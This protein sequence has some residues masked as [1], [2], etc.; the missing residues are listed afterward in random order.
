MAGKEI[1]VRGVHPT[2]LAV[3]DAQAES[4]N[5][6]RNE[7]IKRI[8]DEQA[9]LLGDRTEQSRMERALN[10]NFTMMQEVL[11]VLGEVKMQLARNGGDFYE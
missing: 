8:L 3:I 6:S 11:S 5:L 7:Y 10:A 2:T 4:L 1:K 9:L